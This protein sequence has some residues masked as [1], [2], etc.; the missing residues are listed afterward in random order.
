MHRGH[1]DP[2]AERPYP[3]LAAVLVDVFQFGLMGGTKAENP[4]SIVVHFEREGEGEEGH[5]HF[6]DNV[7]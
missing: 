6:L 3:F 5:S 1:Y 7:R 2:I 4:S